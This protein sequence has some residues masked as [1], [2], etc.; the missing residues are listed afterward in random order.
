TGEEC[1]EESDGCV[2]CQ[3]A[4]TTSDD[5]LP[6]NPCLEPPLCNT[7]F[8]TCDDAFPYP[9]GTECG[10][11]MECHGGECVEL[12]EMDED[13][14]ETECGGPGLCNLGTGFCE[15]DAPADDGTVCTLDAEEPPGGICVA[16]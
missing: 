2:D 3:W 9:D 10:D 16:Q 6:E 1:D 4:C 11:G 13:C 15:Y 12:C 8:H 5:C 14:E 7:A